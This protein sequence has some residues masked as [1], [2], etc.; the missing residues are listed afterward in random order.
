MLPNSNSAIIAGTTRASLERRSTDAKS[1]RSVPT[2]A[3][4][5][6]FCDRCG[7]G[8]KRASAEYRG[9]IRSRPN[10]QGG[11]VHLFPTALLLEVDDARSRC[12][13][14][15]RPRSFYRHIGPFHRWT[16]DSNTQ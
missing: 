11:R 3:C 2:C 7:I 10:S 1:A 13:F 15:V 5:F 9:A 16:V 12:V 8:V 6:P 14:Y 4:N